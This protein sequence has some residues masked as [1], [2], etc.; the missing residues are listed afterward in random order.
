M[1]S[2]QKACGLIQRARRLS[3]PKED[4]LTGF[5]CPTRIRWYFVEHSMHSIFFSFLFLA[6]LILTGCEP[7]ISYGACD[8]DPNING[9]CCP[10]NSTCHDSQPL[11]GKKLS[12]VVD[13]HP[14]CAERVCVT[15]R[16]SSSFCSQECAQD[17]DCP[18]NGCCVPYLVNDSNSMYCID[19]ILCP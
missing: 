3:K 4:G 2:Y 19:Q 14:D 18:N 6:T 5:V 1:D 13:D 8:Y 12:C 10:V 17:S 16:G 9:V 11:E 15:Y 7:P